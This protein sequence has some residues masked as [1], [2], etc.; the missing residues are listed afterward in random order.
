MDNIGYYKMKKLLFL[1]FCIAFSCAFI[2]AQEFNVNDVKKLMVN[3]PEK[4]IQI[5]RIEVPQKLYTLVMGENPSV[6]KGENNP[7]ENISGLDAIYFCNKLSRLSG[8]SPVYSINDNKDERKWNYIP[9]KGNYITDVIKIDKEADGY[10]LPTSSEWIYAAKGGQNFV[11]AGSDNYHEVGWKDRS[12]KRAHTFPVAQK[13]PNGYGLYDMTCNVS[14]MIEFRD[15]ISPCAI[16]GSYSYFEIECKIESLSNN[17]SSAYKGSSNI[18]FRIV[19]KSSDK[20]LVNQDF[21]NSFAKPG[22]TGDIIFD[23]CKCNFY[24]SF[25]KIKKMYPDFEKNDVVEDLIYY[26]SSFINDNEIWQFIFFK[27]ELVQ[28]IKTYINPSE[29]C[30]SDTIDE[31][32]S[33]YGESYN[34]PKQGI[35]VWDSEGVS[36]IY[37]TYEDCDLFR[38]NYFDNPIYNPLN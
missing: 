26:Y 7:V 4:N 28:F 27:N 21:F 3:L 15:L 36:L 30:I 2:F 13:K 29:T 12:K 14:E 6:H 25:D 23:I 31:F 19:C 9:H 38:L 5:L 32:V 35:V 37:E 18:G 22:T 20:Q 1:F 33:K 17:F 24:D 10:R 11:Y 16:G 34:T 8:L